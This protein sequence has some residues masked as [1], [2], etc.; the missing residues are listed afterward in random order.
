MKKILF[1]MNSIHFG[2]AERVIVNLANKFSE[3]NYEVVFVTSFISN[4]EYTLNSKVRRFVLEN[5]VLEQS[6][7]KRNFF[8]TMKLRSLCKR[9][10]PDIVISFM[11]EPNFRAILATRFLRIKTLISIRNDPNKEYPTKLFRLV[12]KVLYPLAS[13]CVFQT[14]DAKKW[15]DRRIQK[16]SKIILNH[17]DEKF[18]NV[19]FTGERKDIVTVGRLEKQKNH[20][21]LIEAFAK[22][23]S[24]FPN[25]N[26]IIYGEGSLKKELV[27]LSK[28]LNIE[29]KVIFKG[30]T[31]EIHEKIKDAKIFVLSSDYE[32]LPNVVMEAMTLGVPVISTDCP[33]GGPRML[34]DNNKN[35]ILVKVS[36]VEEI[37]S[38]IVRILRDSSFAELLGANAKKVAKEFEPNKIFEKWEKYIREII[39]DN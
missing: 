11:A 33:C 32:G 1:Y 7:L 38:S 8:R 31:K 4:E 34:L 26:L 28:K 17:V 25:E 23:A 9:E 36:D 35:G 12:A 24:I 3:K 14:E 37:A 20:K 13:G 6:F 5:K 10:K 21:L 2:G 16:K 27:E 18:Y 39:Y 30:E 29:D 19:N 22:T 15:F